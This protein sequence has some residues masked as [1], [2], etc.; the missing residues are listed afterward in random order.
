MLRLGIGVGQEGRPVGR[1]L[2]FR[3]SLVCLLVPLG[4]LLSGTA[5]FS[6]IAV[7]AGRTTPSGGEV[8]VQ[9]D[10]AVR[11]PGFLNGEGHLQGPNDQALTPL[12]PI[13]LTM[14]DN[15]FIS[16]V[17]HLKLEVLS[18]RYTHGAGMCQGAYA[19]EPPVLCLQRLTMQV[20]LVQSDIPSCKV[21]ARGV[22]VIEAVAVSAKQVNGQPMNFPSSS[23][24]TICG[25]TYSAP[26]NHN[27]YIVII[28]PQ[29]IT[30]PPPASTST[31]ATHP[32]SAQPPC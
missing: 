29:S 30:S 20:T 26:P 14:T 25:K 28:G 11:E 18:A 6:A 9:R 32:S 7:A 5:F 15:S 24:V 23:E 17:R 21:P 31:Q 13:V 1:P 2:A 16:G 8:V 3:R 19:G 22:V 10:F 27:T 4:A 12:Q